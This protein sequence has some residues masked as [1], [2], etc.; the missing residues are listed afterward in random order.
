MNTFSHI[1][2][3]I[4]S[5]LF[6]L[7]LLVLSGLTNTI[8]AQNPWTNIVEINRL[9]GTVPASDAQ[10]VFAY[11]FTNDNQPLDPIYGTLNV[12]W[13]IGEQN[14]QIHN[15]TFDNLNSNS[16]KVRIY[17]MAFCNGI[18]LG[19]NSIIVDKNNPHHTV[20]ASISN[21]RASY[22]HCSEF[23]Q[24]TNPTVTPSPT[25]SPTPTMVPIPTT[26]PTPVV[27]EIILLP[28]LGLNTGF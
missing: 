6:V 24:S 17:Y 2:P 21:W 19:Q 14:N 27:S 13:S 20:K 9:I 8:Y 28:A 15:F 5:I 25:P 4:A 26:Q 22:G 3:I 23:E 11:G 1:K 7:V 10:F 18:V 12:D 16:T